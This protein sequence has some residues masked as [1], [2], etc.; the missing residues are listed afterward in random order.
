M[1]L[2]QM[3]VTDPNERAALKEWQRSESHRDIPGYDTDK[4]ERVRLALLKLPRTYAQW[5][6]QVCEP[7]E[8]NGIPK[9]TTPPAPHSKFQPTKRVN[10]IARANYGAG[11]NKRACQ[12]CGSVV[13]DVITTRQTNRLIIR[14]RTC[15]GCGT[16]RTTQEVLK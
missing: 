14:Y 3:V 10:T 11:E 4:V 1:A 8:I 6:A 12:N 13:S 2:I 15:L 5:K 16:K 7:D 9:A